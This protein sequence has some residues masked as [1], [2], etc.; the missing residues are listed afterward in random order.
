V[1]KI[2]TPREGCVYLKV[3]P[4]CGNKLF[5]RAAVD[6]GQAW[7]IVDYCRECGA[8]FFHGEFRGHLKNYFDWKIIEEIKFE[9]EKV[10]FT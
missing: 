8:T 4:N 3:C 7:Q 10:V 5:G 2:D 9:K 6:I 1:G